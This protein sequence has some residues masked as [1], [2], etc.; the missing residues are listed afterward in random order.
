MEWNQ[1]S[2]VELGLR[3]A[4][5][6]QLGIAA[7]NLSLVPLMK[8]KPDLDR[9][10]LLIREVFR[11]HLVFITLTVAAFAILTWRFANEIAL[12]HSA[13]ATWLAAVIGIFWG[14]RSLMQWTSYS[15]THWRGDALR[16][17]LHWLLF[18][19]YGALAAIYLVAASNGL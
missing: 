6:T 18:L 2:V 13:L 14:A 4:A 17:V 8:W 19:G 5:V 15:A 11:V 1:P 7:L 10:P 9:L 16:T 12:A 3:V